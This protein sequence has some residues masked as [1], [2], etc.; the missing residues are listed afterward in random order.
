[1]SLLKYT[2]SQLLVAL[3]LIQLVHMLRTKTKLVKE[4]SA[5]KR[6][7]EN[8]FPQLQWKKPSSVA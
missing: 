3:T 1:M 8:G 5:E 4:I 6:S 2:S 7:K